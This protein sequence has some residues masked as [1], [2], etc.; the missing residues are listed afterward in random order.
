VGAVSAPTRTDSA[1]ATLAANT[2]RFL[3]VDAVEKARSGHPGMPMGMADA[4]YVLWSRFLRHDP[5]DPAWP[6][7][8]RFV[9]S[10]GHGS[11]LLYS[12]LHLSGYELPMDEL[13]RFR[14]LGS[15]TPGHPEYGHT[16]GVETTTGPLGQGL[17][18]AVGMALAS[19]MED[20][21]FAAPGADGRGA[22]SPGAHRVF[23]IAGDGCLMEGI[24][25]EASSLAGYLA[26][27]N[28]VVM[29]D[30]NRITI[31]G[32]TSI[33]FTDDT[34]KRFEAYGWQVLR[35]D[36]LDHGAVATA[37]EQAIAETSRPSL[38]ICRSHIGYGAPHKQDTAHAHGEPL[39]PE[40][41]LAAKRALGWPESPAFL[42]P[43]E[44]SA[45]FSELRARWQR[46]RSEWDAALAR[47]RTADP[48]R[49]ERWAVFR[50]RRIPGGL[51]E[52]LCEGAPATA[53]AT[54]VHGQAVIQK[55]AA[56]LPGMVG[57][58]ADL[59]ASTRTK[60]ADSGYVSAK[61][62][63]GRN[64]HFGVREHAMTAICSGLA[65]S[66]GWLPF[67]AS[68][69]T[70]T[71]YARPS[72]R[73]AALMKLRV[74]FAYTHDSIFLGEDGPTHQA[75]E[76]LSA[77]R[78]IP[79]LL[80]IRPA[81]G[82]ETAAAWGLALERSEGPTLL[83]LSRQAVPALARPA[84]FSAAELRRG[85]SLLR[86]SDARDAITLIATG[87]EVGVAVDAAERLATVG[88]AARVVSMPAPQLFA[89]Q[90]EAWRRHLLPPG[91]RRV[92]I[93]AGVT[94]YWRAIVG[95]RGLTIGVDRYGE[96]AP[97]EVL[98]GHFGLT[99]EA[100]AKR[101]RDWAP[102]A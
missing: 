49:A 80:V 2:I 11:M 9:L 92:S 5:G 31:D 53:A 23:A 13:K 55:A 70:F 19:R 94:E 65:L 24:S 1:L 45:H 61:D 82:L 60:I 58:S 78:L 86:D 62:F 4:A 63:S 59:E 44:V 51:V 21:R 41:T 25:H 16:P 6:G 38:I 29:Y 74:I 28:L 75:V 37:L 43:E 88:L 48:A 40:E 42:V 54:R 99:G 7:R 34:A 83:A 66:G 3:A 71:D 50:E 10:A 89:E 73:L 69:L 33:T 97:A 36:A 100:V 30:D 12:L 81:D 52:R 79:N 18:N 95:E 20:A 15:R 77:L 64:L 39:G 56:L 84:S 91:G 72:I 85:A 76:H 96:S 32:S 27:G 8:D 17:A 98:A 93:E 47:W 26:L 35:A 46:E 87:S 102:R 101:V 22:F 57:G 14:Q 67:S 68:F 90:D